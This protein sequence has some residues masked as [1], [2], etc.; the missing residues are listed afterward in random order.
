MK[1]LLTLS[2]L[3]LLFPAQT[4]AGATAT[5]SE[6]RWEVGVAVG[7]ASLPQYMGSD[8]RYTI[9]A[10]IPYIVYRGE[11]LKIDRGSITSEL[12]GIHGLTLDASLGAALPVRN[13]NR[14]RAGMP[15]LKF[16]L[17]AGP[18]LNWRMID[19]DRYSYT[20][21]L[22]WRGIMDTSGSWLGWVTEP[23]M[24]AEFRLGERLELD[25]TAGLLYGSRAYMDHYYSVAPI[26]ATATRPAYQARRGLHS[27]GV[28]AAVTY[29]ITDTLT[30]FTALRYRN[31]ASGVVADSPLVKDRNYLSVTAGIAWSFWTSEEQVPAE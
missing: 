7:A 12:F 21:R 20:I 10:P 4:F 5:K 8:E 14:A 26:Y 28:R 13:K 29:D 23:E 27:L 11:R 1:R 17:Q 9:A 22:P 2:L 6:P 15:S 16:S 25:L 30:L 24:N 31:L 18:R 19:T 3:L